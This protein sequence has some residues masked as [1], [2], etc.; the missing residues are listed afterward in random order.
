MWKSF[1][2]PL[3]YRSEDHKEQGVTCAVVNKFSLLRNKNKQL[4]DCTGS[5]WNWYTA[6]CNENP[7]YVFPEKEFRSLR[8]NFHIH[9]SVCDEYIYSQDRSTFSCR[10]IGRPIV[11]IYQLLRY[12][13]GNWDW[14]RAIPFLGIFVS[15]FRYC[16][17]AVY[18]FGHCGMRNKCNDAYFL[19]NRS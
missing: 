2:Q 12:E 9:V 4:K 14:G 17:F 16:V 19:Q 11:G 15:N 10:R 18:S 6:H 13:C 5:A 1:P 8:P 3:I 7:F